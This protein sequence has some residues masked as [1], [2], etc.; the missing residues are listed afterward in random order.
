MDYQDERR[1]GGDGK[2]SKE[3]YCSPG[4]LYYRYPTLEQVKLFVIK[5]FAIWISKRGEVKEGT[6]VGDGV[7][8]EGPRGRR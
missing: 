1:M 5:D 7:V 6:Q 2:G 3:P 4:L 8:R